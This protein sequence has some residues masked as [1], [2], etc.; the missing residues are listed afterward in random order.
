MKTRSRCVGIQQYTLV[1]A[2]THERFFFSFAILPCGLLFKHIMMGHLLECVLYV[3]IILYELYNV[4]NDGSTVGLGAGL[5]KRVLRL[6][7]FLVLSDVCGA[8]N[9]RKA[10]NTPSAPRE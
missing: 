1:R 6:C 3:C 8:Y 5:W 4:S 9:G 2:P 7:I 10:K